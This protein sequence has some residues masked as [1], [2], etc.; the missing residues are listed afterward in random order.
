MTHGARVGGAAGA[1]GLA[2]SAVTCA[3]L[4]A[5]AEV[6]SRRVPLNASGFASPIFL[7][8]QT[9][10]ACFGRSTKKPRQVLHFL[11]VC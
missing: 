4:F 1:P 9:V 8:G 6:R 10:R 11:S 3:R 2:D 5:A 7:Y